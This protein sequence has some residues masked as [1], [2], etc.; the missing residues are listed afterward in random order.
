MRYNYLNPNLLFV[1]TGEADGQPGVSVALLDTVS[2]ALLHQALHP[3]SAGPVHA[4][5]SENWA[6]YTLRDTASLRQQ[7]RAPDTQDGLTSY[8]GWGLGLGFRVGV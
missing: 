7:V 6:A 5:V 2:G 1:A 8:L 4:V 3:A